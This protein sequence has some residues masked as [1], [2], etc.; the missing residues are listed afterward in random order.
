MRPKQAI[1]HSSQLA[2]VANLFFRADYVAIDEQNRHTNP[3]FPLITISPCTLPQF[4]ATDVSK[5]ANR[6]NFQQMIFVISE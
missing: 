2:A 4:S 6:N 1:D 5:N 3:L